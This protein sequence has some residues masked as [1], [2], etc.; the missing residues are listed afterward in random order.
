MIS[1]ESKV[2]KKNKQAVNQDMFYLAV[3]L[4]VLT[5]LAFFAGIY[6][7]VIAGLAGV[8][9]TLIRSRDWAT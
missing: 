7:M 9:A 2:I 4:L 6:P 3:I 8:I 1:C 5:A